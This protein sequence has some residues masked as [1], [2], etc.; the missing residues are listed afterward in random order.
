MDLTRRLHSRLLRFA[1]SRGG[2]WRLTDAAKLCEA[3]QCKNKDELTDALT[4]LQKEGLIAVRKP[5]E[6]EATLSSAGDGNQARSTLE[7]CIEIGNETEETSFG[8]EPFEISS[9]FDGPI[10][11]DYLDQKEQRRALAALS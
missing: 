5:I 9:T 8:D 4:Q 7:V 3:L 11:R 1:C 2:G 10:L 6:P